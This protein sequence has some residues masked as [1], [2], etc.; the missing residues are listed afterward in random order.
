ML[1]RG[2]L[3][4]LFCT[5]FFLNCF[6]ARRLTPPEEVDPEEVLDHLRLNEKSLRSLALYL[7]FKFRG[8]GKRF[9]TEAEVFYEESGAFT[10]YFKSASHLNVLKSVIRNDSVSFYLPERNEY[11]HDSYDNFSRTKGWEWGIGLEDFLNL[12]IGKNGFGKAPLRF[13]KRVKNNLIYLSQDES[14]EKKFWVDHR[15]N[16]VTR[17]E[18]TN[19]NTRQVLKIDYKNYRDYDGWELPRFLEIKIPAEKETLKVRFKKRK[20]NL[21]LSEKIFRIIIPDDA[22]RVWLK[23]KD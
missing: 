2:F 20:I 22:R 8:K 9:S 21:P 10:I 19:K 1:R 23:E 11:Y 3:F 5:L 12:I 14:W 4:F 7:E 17:S 6:P 18:W 15:K 16:Q 13:I